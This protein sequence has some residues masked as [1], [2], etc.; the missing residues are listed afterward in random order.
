MSKRKK[1]KRGCLL[2]DYDRC[3][4][5]HAMIGH[6]AHIVPRSYEAAF[7]AWWE[8]SKPRPSYR[9][10]SLVYAAMIWVDFNAALHIAGNAKGIRDAAR[11]AQC[12]AAMR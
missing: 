5:I 6:E 7:F 2:C 4:A 1:R 11:L 8:R 12:V 10:Q 9:T 3:S